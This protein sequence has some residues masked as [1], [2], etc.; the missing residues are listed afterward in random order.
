MKNPQRV[1][2]NCEPISPID[3]VCHDTA[4]QA[5]AEGVQMTHAT[6][7]EF[8]DDHVSHAQIKLEQMTPELTEKNENSTSVHNTLKNITVNLEPPGLA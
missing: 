2:Y 4:R 6:F 5:T 7:Y 8:K 3:Q 1:W